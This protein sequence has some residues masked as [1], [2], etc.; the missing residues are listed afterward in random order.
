MSKKEMWWIVLP[1][2]IGGAVLTGAA[3]HYID[4]FWLD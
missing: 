3:I 4:L 1:I 2:L